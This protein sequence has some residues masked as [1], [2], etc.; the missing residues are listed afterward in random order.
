MSTKQHRRITKQV[1]MGV[2]NHRKLKTDAFMNGIKMS[3][4]LDNILELY[5]SYLDKSVDNE[6]KKCF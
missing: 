1:R 3:D 4:L 6:T 5:Y 2:E